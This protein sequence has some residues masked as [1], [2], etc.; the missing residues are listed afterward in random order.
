MRGELFHPLPAITQ[1]YATVLFGLH[2]FPITVHELTIFLLKG[3]NFPRLA[4]F[5]LSSIILSYMSGFT[6]LQDQFQQQ[7]SIVF[8]FSN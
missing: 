1:L 5:V 4:D 8:S 2:S 7:K 3:S 6:S